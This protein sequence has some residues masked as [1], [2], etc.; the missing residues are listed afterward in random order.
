MKATYGKTVP[1]KRS[2]RKG[3]KT[4]KHKVVEDIDRFANSDEVVLILDPEDDYAS[5]VSFYHTVR[6][7]INDTKR[8]STMIAYVRGN[9]VYVEKF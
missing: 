3:R 4:V 1:S 2:S 7:I 9:Y 6:N 5:V 8:T